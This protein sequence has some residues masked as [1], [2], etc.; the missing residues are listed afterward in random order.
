MPMTT[1]LYGCDS[2]N[3]HKYLWQYECAFKVLYNNYS[4]SCRTTIPMLF[5]L[6]HWVELY[7]KLSILKMS[8]FSKSNSLT[9]HL[10][11]IHDIR[12]LK[13]G[14]F[15]HYNI[16]KKEN[17]AYFSEDKKYLP[18]FEKLIEFFI[19]FDNQSFSFRY[20]EDKI[21]NQ[22]FSSEQEIDIKDIGQF[23]TTASLVF[24]VA[25]YIYSEE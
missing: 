11:D 24:E 16:L 14:F 15:E 20:H 13:N 18:D 2:D 8:K 3:I 7:F 21:G 4:S 12:K 6:R 1:T 25:S 22:S 17:P 10:N 23:Y 19:Q 5:I 9:S